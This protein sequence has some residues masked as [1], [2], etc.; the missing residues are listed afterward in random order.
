MPMGCLTPPTTVPP[1]CLMA[2]VAAFSIA[3]PKAKSAVMKNQLL[4][5]DSTTAFVVPTD[6]ALVSSAQWI[7]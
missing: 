3:V 5:P 1:A 4:P 7:V 2:S 6:R